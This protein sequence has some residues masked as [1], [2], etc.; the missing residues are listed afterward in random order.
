LA[1]TGVG[2]F[3]FGGDFGLDP[4]GLIGRGTLIGFV[5][6]FQT[7]GRPAAIFVSSLS[8]S[9]GVMSVTFRVRQSGKTN[10]LSM[11]A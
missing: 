6:F 7:R 11:L 2:L 9:V 10:V 8:T 4:A 5:A 1:R 3:A